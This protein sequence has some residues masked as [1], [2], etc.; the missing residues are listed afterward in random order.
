MP[1]LL[2]AVPALAVLWLA[3]ALA[4]WEEWDDRRRRERR[5]KRNLQRMGGKS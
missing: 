1:Y 2:I 5:V 3:F 4:S